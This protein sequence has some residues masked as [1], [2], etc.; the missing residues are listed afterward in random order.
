VTG[1]P[2]SLVLVGTPIGNLG[3]LSPRAVEALRSA[4]VVYCEDTRRT[5]ALLTHAGVSGVPLRS[6]HQHNE[7]ERQPEVLDAVARGQTVAVVSDAGMPGVSDPG[8]RVVS[9]AARAGLTV[10]VVPGPSAA[11]A[12]LV[13][14]GLPAGRFCF[15]GFLPRSGRERKERLS[16]VAGERRTTVIYEAPGRVAGTLRQL[17]AACGSDRRVAV[18]R[19]LTKLHE[20]V[21]RGD[22]A[23]A[24][25][26]AEETGRLRGEVVIVVAGATATEETVGDRELTD[27]LRLRLDHGERTRSAVDSVAADFGVPRRRVYDLALD[28]RSDEEP[29]EAPR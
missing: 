13:V 7:D 26:W 28:D 2:G 21:W 5:R 6:L 16:V 1:D 23:G 17:E 3:D 22:L 24:L 27:A 10:T 18:A 15:E 14:S 11:L 9:A 8:S 20:E 12:A 25:S 19:E 4:D 29:M